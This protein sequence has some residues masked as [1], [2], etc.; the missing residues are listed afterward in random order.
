M[1]YAGFGRIRKIKDKK[2]M[3]TWAV[4]IMNELIEK[5]SSY[6]YQ[7]TG[8]RPPEDAV[9]ESTG[10]EPPSTP[11]TIDDSPTSTKPETIMKKNENGLGKDS[12][13]NNFLD[14]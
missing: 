10:I 11:P 9:R 2:E 7:Y 3:N 5:E 13:L 4:Q 6:K 14:A 12:E 8:G 1:R